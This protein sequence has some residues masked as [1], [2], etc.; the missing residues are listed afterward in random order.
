M[1]QVRLNTE[2]RRNKN[3]LHSFHSMIFALFLMVSVGGNAQ[4]EMHVMS[5]RGAALGGASV[6]LTDEASAMHNIAALANLSGVNVAVSYKP[7]YLLGNMSNKWAAASY[8]LTKTGT[9]LLGY[10]HFGNQHYSEQCLSLGY[11]QAVSSTVALGATLD[12]L[13]SGVSD[14]YYQ[15]LQGFTFTVAMQMSIGQHC[16]LGARIFNPAAV[17]LGDGDRLP[18]RLNIGCAYQF[19]AEWQATLEVEK[20]LEA[21]VTFRA[22][23][24]YLFLKYFAARIGISTEP[25]VFC[26]GVGVNVGRYRFD[27]AATAHQVL[28]LTP[29]L[30]GVVS[31]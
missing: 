21:P 19:S 18:T 20:M 29:M 2:C 25:L 3:R 28:G 27:V 26:F 7:N 8:H 17:R 30:G 14:A 6:A 22:G 23:A 15:P 11:A 12:Y 24:E 1:H 31:F 10:H 16:T 9:A 4:F 13:Y 5:I